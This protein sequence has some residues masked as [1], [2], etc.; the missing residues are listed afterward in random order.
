MKSLSYLIL[1]VA[2]GIVIGVLIYPGLRSIDS[3]KLLP[4]YLDTIY[5]SG[6]DVMSE[7]TS[8]N[9]KPAFKEPEHP[10]TL[11]NY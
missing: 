6:P 3:V 7:D 8:L 1:G 10:T 4:A 2:I 5:Y 11:S 9:T